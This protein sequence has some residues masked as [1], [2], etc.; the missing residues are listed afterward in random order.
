M[1][2]IGEEKVRDW[3]GKVLSTDGKSLLDTANFGVHATKCRARA[4][5]R[6]LHENAR[7]RRVGACSPNP[8]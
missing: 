5:D 3:R 1:S 4:G 6:S 7:T 8:S 2:F